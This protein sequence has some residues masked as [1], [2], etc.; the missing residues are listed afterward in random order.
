M[1]Y[2]EG[3]EALDTDH[4]PLTHTGLLHLRIG[5]YDI[6][7]HH[8][9]SALILQNLTLPALQSLTISEF[10]ISHDDF[11]SFLTRSSPPLQSLGMQIPSDDWSSHNVNQYFR[12]LPGLKD[13]QVWR[14]YMSEDE[15]DPFP[16]FLD[17]LS[18]APD[19]LP[20]LRTL[21]IW[22]YFPD[23]PQYENLVSLLGARG[24]E[25]LGSFKLIFPGWAADPGPDADIVAALRQLVEN[26]MDIHI[27][28]EEGSFI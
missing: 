15:D 26:G 16:P 14:A 2:E 12:L 11:L 25:A 13:L 3:V 4:T 6:N 23:R 27:G 9:S 8:T 28:P 24:S 20:N 17:V 10:D 7:E 21:T 18:S 22:G 19:F 5:Q 1:Y